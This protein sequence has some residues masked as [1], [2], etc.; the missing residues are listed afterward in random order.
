MIKR[1]WLKQR[2]A[3]KSVCKIR[4]DLAK[5]LGDSLVGGGR[6]TDLV[7]DEHD[8]VLDET[9]EIGPEFA[10]GN[11]ISSLTVLDEAEEDEASNEV[12]EGQDDQTEKGRERERER[13]G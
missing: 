1:G 5:D 13:G 2:R 9:G 3:P 11:G 10:V 6:S 4:N 8:T 12:H 7:D